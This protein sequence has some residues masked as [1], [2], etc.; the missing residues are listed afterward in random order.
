M[1]TPLDRMDA[2][3]ERHP[4]LVKRLCEFKYDVR[5]E[6]IEFLKKQLIMAGKEAMIVDLLL[7]VEHV[8]KKVLPRLIH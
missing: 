5:E 2:A 8:E 6:Q 3:A 7:V 1:K 4:T